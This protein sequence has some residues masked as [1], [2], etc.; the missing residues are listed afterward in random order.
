MN[1]TGLDELL[2][3]MPDTGAISIDPPEPVPRR[4]YSSSPPLLRA[5]RA[6]SSSRESILLSRFGM[7]TIMT[8]ES[9][10]GSPTQESHVLESDLNNDDL[11]QQSQSMSSPSVRRENLPLSHDP[12]PLFFPLSQSSV[13]DNYAQEE[14]TS[15][16]E[17]VPVS[18]PI[19]QDREMIPISNIEDS[20]FFDDL[21]D[22]LEGLNEYLAPEDRPVVTRQTKGQLIKADDIPHKPNK[23][24]SFDQDMSLNEQLNSVDQEKSFPLDSASGL[25]SNDQVMGDASGDVGNTKQ[26]SENE[27]HILNNMP[28]M[29]NSKHSAGWVPQIT[30][31]HPTTKSPVVSY[32]P[33]PI[34]QAPIYSVQLHPNTTPSHD[35]PDSV[36]MPVAEEQEE[37][38]DMMADLDA[39]LNSGGVK[40]VD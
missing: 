37:D 21:D 7:T 24:S 5:K 38:F 26:R 2:R 15:K 3:H 30:T 18:A 34:P 23:G 9:A 39:W 27:T 10:T 33:L 22:F 1:L 25:T 19:D 16:P 6:R 4:L 29:N 14:K 11:R 8:E 28:N 35:T 17:Q 31:K 12:E 13:S 20:E 32:Q 36:S 40:I